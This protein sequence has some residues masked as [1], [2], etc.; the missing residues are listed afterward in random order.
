MSELYELFSLYGFLCGALGTVLPYLPL[1]YRSIS[2]S[3]FEVGVL[4][5]LPPLI[6][7]LSSPS[8][9]YI[10]D[11]YSIHFEVHAITLF[12]TGVL[13]LF[14]MVLEGLDQFLMLVILISILKATALPLLGL[15]KP[16]YH[17]S[18]SG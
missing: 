7:F 8:W 6:Q 17:C 18:F 10:C 11:K 2:F 3:H 4:T 1:F 9:G 13:T 15:N 5:L 12:L 14:L 16:N